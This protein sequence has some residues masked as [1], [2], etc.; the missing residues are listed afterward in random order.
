MKKTPVGPSTIDRLLAQV[1]SAPFWFVVLSMSGVGATSVGLGLQYG[2]GHG[3]L[4]F[5]VICLGAAELVRRGMS[6]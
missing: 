1:S 6:A 2:L 5:G 4:G 3:L